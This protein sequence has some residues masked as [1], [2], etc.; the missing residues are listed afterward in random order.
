MR[1]LIHFVILLTSFC[2]GQKQLVNRFA[3][4]YNIGF[5]KPFFPLS[6][7]FTA[8]FAKSPM[9]DIGFR[10]MLNDRFGLRTSVATH[11]LNFENPTID[12]EN[13]NLISQTIYFK[14][15]IDAVTNLGT[16][17]GWREKNSKFGLLLN[18][19]LGYTIVKSKN[20]LADTKWTSDLTELMINI[21]TGVSL[22]V[23]TGP[24]GCVQ[25]NFGTLTHLSQTFTFDMNSSGVR[26]GFDGVM[27]YSS[28]GYTW[29][30][31]PNLIH[32][33]WLKK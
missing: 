11:L 20:S 26:P 19:G 9:I 33:D 15:N 18:T 4:D 21:N 27:L 7:N 1:Y 2:F 16:I 32:Y 29:Y 17:F 24:K 3:T 23:K 31:G 8:E 22:L 6:Q 10:V 14:N 30:I 25:A 12:L 13:S 5:S 28:I